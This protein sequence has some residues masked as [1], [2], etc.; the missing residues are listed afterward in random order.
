MEAWGVH[1][2]SFCSGNI[3]TYQ[4]KVSVGQGFL[5]DRV[6][7]D[8]VLTFTGSKGQGEVILMF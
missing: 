5:W 1:C 8:L 4:Y 6:D 3:Y 7:K 2:Q